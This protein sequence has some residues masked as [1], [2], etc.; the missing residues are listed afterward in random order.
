MKCLA[1]ALAVSA[2]LLLAGPAL[3]QGPGPGGWPNKPVKIIVPFAPAGPT[4]MPR[5]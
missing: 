4:D 5:G 3:A 1:P 2:A